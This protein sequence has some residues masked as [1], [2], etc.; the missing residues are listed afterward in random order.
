LVDVV[1][2]GKIGVQNL[3]EFWVLSDDV[4][5]VFTSERLL[6]KTLLHF[7][8]DLFVNRVVTVK[9]SGK[10]KVFRTQAVKEVLTEDPADISINRLLNRQLVALE[11]GLERSIGQTVDQRSFLDDLVNRVLD[12]K[13]TCIL[14]RV[15][16]QAHDSNAIGELL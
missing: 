12:G 6:T 10:S 1:N 11:E 16:V 14:H 5:D 4:Q 7:V 3:D 2:G 13:T 9:N 8:Q 15:E